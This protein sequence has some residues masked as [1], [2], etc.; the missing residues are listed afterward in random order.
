MKPLCIICSTASPF[1]LTKDGYDL[2]RCPSCN[3][4]FVYPEPQNSFL[5]EKVY[6]YESGYQSNKRGNFS[7]VLPDVKT[8]K[9][10]SFLDSLDTKGKL[11]D[12]GCSSGEFMYH[13]GRRGFETY[14]VELNR[15][16]AEVAQAQGLNVFN[17]YLADAKFSPGSFNVI[18]LG[19]IIEHVTSP[20]DLIREC[21]RILAA[22]GYI[23]ISTPNLD[24]F[25]SDMTYRLYQ[26]FHIPWSS[27]TPP[28]HLFQ[29]SHNNL[30]LLMS[31]YGL[32]KKDIFYMRPPRLTYE[33]GSL[34]LLKRWKT[35]RKIK[36]LFFMIFSFTCYTILYVVDI[37]LGFFKQSDFSMVGIYTKN[38]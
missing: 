14:G 18:F 35:S 11:L 34:H 4:V 13:A 10:I 33:L 24:C 7:Q 17:G 19:D 9:I 29:F 15:R 25:W 8:E 20:D 31:R 2:Y 5:K 16:T 1:L 38:V 36:D 12:V 32:L 3:L 26:W 28:Y 37:L 30:N 23:I 21:T 6:S 27:L 22:G